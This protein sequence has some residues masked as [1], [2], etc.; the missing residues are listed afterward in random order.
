M[1]GFIISNKRFATSPTARAGGPPPSE[2]RS[3]EVSVGLSREIDGGAIASRQCVCAEKMR[4]VR[5]A[6][7][8]LLRN[9]PDAAG[10]HRLR[11]APHREPTSWCRSGKTF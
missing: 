6:R 2:L 3:I 5:R 7:S 4:L 10:Q 8:S 9:S 1:P 11:M